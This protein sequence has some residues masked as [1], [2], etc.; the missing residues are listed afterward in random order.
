MAREP[1]P[2]RGDYSYI[3]PIQVRWGD[4]D[5]LGHINNVQ[6]VRYLEYMVV[7][8][9]GEECGESWT[10]GAAIPFAAENS[11]RFLRPINAGPLGP[12]G[13]T[14]D[15]GLSIAR[16]GTSSVHYAMA[17]FEQGE[18]AAAATGT[19]VHVWVDSKTHR[20]VPIPDQARAAYERHMR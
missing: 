1:A 20:P 9:V 4:F 7:N 15:A 18:D 5:L 6:Y 19:W 16:V 17:L 10:R 12:V 14:L 2:T 3:R 8:F 13:I 11:C